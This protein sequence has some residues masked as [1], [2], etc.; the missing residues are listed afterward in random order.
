V[1]KR[2]TLLVYEMQV[3]EPDGQTIR[4]VEADDLLLLIMLAF[5]F[6]CM[7]LPAAPLKRRTLAIPMSRRPRWRVV[8]KR[9]T[10]FDHATDNLTEGP[11]LRRRSKGVFIAGMF[12]AASARFRRIMSFKHSW[13]PE[14]PA[15]F[16]RFRQYLN[17]GRVECD[18]NFFFCSQVAGEKSPA[19][20]DYEEITDKAARNPAN[21]LTGGN[22][23][24]RSRFLKI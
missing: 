22:R 21:L 18:A 8:P 17:I 15:G 11:D 1:A 6:A 2:I 7:T 10:R 16:E 24:Q 12:S 4:T 9:C 14:I 19:T 5:V 3:S 13:I 23:G 20:A